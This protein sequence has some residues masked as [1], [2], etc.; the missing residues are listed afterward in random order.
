MKNITFRADEDLIER[1]R[2]IAH[3]QRK[4]LNEAFREWLA[5]FAQSAGDAHGFDAPMQRLQHV[6]AG[7]HFGRDELNER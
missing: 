5:Q 4:T 1:A 7:R 3:A 6:D 2:S